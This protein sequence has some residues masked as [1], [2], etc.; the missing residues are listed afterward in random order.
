MSHPPLLLLSNLPGMSTIATCS[1]S[2][3]RSR[4]I[5]GHHRRLGNKKIWPKIGARERNVMQQEGLDKSF[6]HIA[7]IGERCKFCFPGKGIVAWLEFKADLLS[8]L[9][10]CPAPRHAMAS[11]LCWWTE[12]TLSCGQAS[13]ANSW[14]VSTPRRRPGSS[15]PPQKT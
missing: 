15:S 3:A 8:N 9:Y 10:N 11:F 6:M 12:L 5:C 2:R 13:P 1:R 4:K 14:P 7:H